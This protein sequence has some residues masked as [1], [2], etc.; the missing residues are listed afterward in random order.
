M[1]PAA[2]PEPEH[3]LPEHLVRR[4]GNLAD[5]AAG[6]GGG[7]GRQPAAE[8]APACWPAATLRVNRLGRM[9]GGGVAAT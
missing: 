4:L 7:G 9:P 2:V 5:L 8:A 1:M 3:K 6:A